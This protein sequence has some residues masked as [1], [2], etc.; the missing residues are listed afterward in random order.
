MHVLFFVYFCT[1]NVFCESRQKLVIIK[2]FHN[3]DKGGNPSAVAY[4]RTPAGSVAS[5]C[6]RLALLLVMLMG[7]G[8]AAFGQRTVAP[9]SGT[10]TDRSTGEPLAFVQIAVPPR[11]DDPGD[12]GYGTVSDINGRF[13]L[14]VTA[15]DTVL[16]F[17]MVGYRPQTV[18]LKKKGSHRLKVSME[19]EVTTLQTVNVTAK[20]GKRDR[21]SR[22]NNPAV[23]LVKRVIEHKRANNVLSS[24]HF[25]RRVFEKLNMCLDQFHPDFENHAFWKHFAFV[26]KYIDRAEFDNAEIL[27]FSIRERMQSQ[28]YRN[29]NLRTLTTAYRADGVDVNMSQEGL[30][31]DLGA[32]FPT[33]DI[34]DNEIAL[35][36][37][38]F[39][40]P[41]STILATTFYH[42]YITD[43]VEVDGQRCI[44]LSFVPSSK[45]NFG[46]VGSM[47]IVCDSSYAVKRCT[48]RV[49][50]AVDLNF[51]RDLNVMQTFER[52][53]TGRYLPTRTDTYGRFYVGKR[54]R[55]IYA[56]Q[57]QLY[58]DYSFDTLI[59]QPD[60]LFTPLSSYAVHPD[61]HKMFRKEWNALRP[62]QLTLAETFL[63]SMRY[64]LMRIPSVRYTIKTVEALLSGYVPTHS[65]R[66]SSRFDIGPIYNMVSHNGTEGLRLRVGGMSRARLNNRNF[67]D[68]YVAYGFK[69]K[70]VKFNLNLIHTF[71][72]KRRFPK[73]SPVG[74]ITLHAGYDIESPGLSFDQYDRDNILM[75]NNKEV[76]AQYVADVQ[77]RLRKNWPSFIDL[78]TWVGAQHIRPTGLLNYYRLTPS[79]TERVESIVYA[80][81]A[82]NLSFTPGTLVG[83]GRTGQNSL[84]N[85]SSNATVITL[86]HEMGILDGFYYN[87]SALN[88]FNRLWFAALG[89]LDVRAQVGIVWNQVP[90][91]KLFIP[92]GNSSLFLSQNSFNTMKPM[93][94]IMDRY[95]SLFATYHMKG[96]ILNHIPLIKRLRFREVLGF[97]LLYGSMSDVNNP[98]NGHLGLYQLPAG[99]SFLTNTPYMEYS[100]GIENILKLI[101]IDYVRRLTYLDEGISP[102]AIKVCL[103]F[104]M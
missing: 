19:P 104:T 25:S 79:G 90:M 54:L 53:S 100:I 96:L 8:A 2:L 21:Y 87:R 50:E 43:T 33:I 26:E 1:E 58:Y 20:K 46:F 82:T 11:A 64:E 101:R 18:V 62:V 98:A 85:L 12:R 35:M 61:A 56:H 16:H 76:P 74:Y 7:S 29:E 10:V 23:E 84:L 31:D 22:K 39:V 42:Y 48:M 15:E 97:N 60:S 75:W 86:S 80:Q 49:P 72:P 44:E 94:F 89:Y 37:V 47:Y 28:N 3:P 17:R 40:S 99:A 67:F 70:Q 38:R 91:P 93:E 36:S 52:D 63:D 6:V 88:A 9:V 13:D 34:F 69:D 92:N 24:D 4:G 103:Q 71:A 45:G 65:S 14:S 83:S 41:L 68:G 27:H 95:V 51:V 32:L 5:L 66:D 59:P 55:Q 81:W 77:L 57:M 102:H 73:E 78:D 30:D